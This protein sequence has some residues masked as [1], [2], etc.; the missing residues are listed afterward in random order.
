MAVVILQ[1]NID[2]CYKIYSPDLYLIE[3]LTSQIIVVYRNQ[4]DGYMCNFL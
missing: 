1:E 2:P 3:N 4:M